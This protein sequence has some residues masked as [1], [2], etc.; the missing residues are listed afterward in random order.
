MLKRLAAA[1]LLLSA[2]SLAVPA[3]A[4]MYGSSA[5]AMH[6][7]TATMSMM[8]TAAPWHRAKTSKGTIWV[9][10]RG[11]A[12]YTYDKD[13]AGKTTCYGACAIAWPPF[14]AGMGAVASGKWTIVMRMG[15]FGSQWA[16]N[17]KPLYFWFKDTAPG[18]VTGDGIDGFHVAR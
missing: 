16:Y 17:G 2:T 12:L 1:G 4:A 6:G 18:Q 7:P 10:S 15:M 3:D 8:T 14:R 9:D 11:F 5:P 13:S